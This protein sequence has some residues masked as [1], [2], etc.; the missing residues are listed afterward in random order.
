MIETMLSQLSA[1]WSGE[2]GL[3]ALGLVFLLS[4]L[5]F[6]PRPPI[7]IF[8]GLVFG[9]VAFPVALAGS[10][11]GA[12][13]AF[14]LSRHLFRSRVHRIAGR[15][16]RLKLIMD[17][18]DAEGWRLLGL[19]RLASPVP[20]T[21][22]NYLFGVTKM[23]VWPYM[24]ATALGSAPQVLAFVYLGMASQMAL[25]AP[26]VSATKLAFTLAGCALFLGVMFLV[27]RRVKSLVTVKLAGQ[28]G[29]QK[30]WETL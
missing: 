27:G 11:L 4:G 13:I 8:G 21:A 29:A 22:S 9:L 24:A 1:D 28:A 25:N 2:T 12:V 16:P 20:G 5:V 14:L 10:T 26:S 17:A 30:E 19:L 15:R 23:G 18:I 3:L 6:I 7:C